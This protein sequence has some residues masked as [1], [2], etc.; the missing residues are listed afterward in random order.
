MLSHPAGLSSATKSPDPLD[1]TFYKHI[2]FWQQ[3]TWQALRNKIK[4]TEIPQDSPIISIYMEDESGKPISHGNKL[5]LRGNLFSYWNDVSRSGEELMNFTDLGLERKEHFR[6]TFEDMYPWLR[7]CEGRWKVDH[8]W[9]NYFSS[10]KKSR[11]TPEPNATKDSKRS[12]AGSKPSGPTTSITKK[13]VTTTDESDLSVGSK[14]GR[15]EPEEP[16]NPSKRQKGK[17]KENVVP[18]NFHPPRPIPKKKVRAILSKVSRSK[19]CS[20]NL[21]ENVPGSIVIYY[22][23]AQLSKLIYFPQPDYHEHSSGPGVRL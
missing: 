1:R 23:V 11:S 10:W 15:E 16:E 8:L 5:A 19:V 2:K 20:L 3:S 14:R 13:P 22:P 9:I 6:K 7:L 12:V 17:E 21:T 18:A 4:N